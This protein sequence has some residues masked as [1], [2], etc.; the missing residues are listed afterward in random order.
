MMTVLEECTVEEQHSVVC[1]LCEKGLNTKDIHK[2]MFPVYCGKCLSCKL[3]HGWRNS[4]K[5]I[6]KSSQMMPN[7]VALMRL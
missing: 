4:L 3:V 7:Q 5:D 6:Q 2:E 1:F